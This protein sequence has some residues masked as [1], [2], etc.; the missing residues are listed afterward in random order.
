MDAI[1]KQDLRPEAL[2]GA[3]ERFE[4]AGR[5]YAASYQA[6]SEAIDL[7]AD[8]LREDKMAD[9]HAQVKT[10]VRNWFDR[11]QEAERSTFN[12]PDADAVTLKGALEKIYLF[13]VPE[14]GIDAKWFDDEGAGEFMVLSRMR[15]EDMTPKDVRR[16]E[17]LSKRLFPRQKRRI[18]FTQNTG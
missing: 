1:V 2:L 5:S 11:V 16:W 9:I 18:I 6:L 17:E 15:E 3:F 13:N 4:R 7:A 12:A 10:I 8:M 14:F